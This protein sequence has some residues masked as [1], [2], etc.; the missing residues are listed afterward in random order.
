MTRT[1]RRGAEVEAAPAEDAAEGSSDDDAAPAGDAAAA[2]EDAGG[3]PDEPHDE[4]S[5]AT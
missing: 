1:S 4:G 5:P 2:D 3:S